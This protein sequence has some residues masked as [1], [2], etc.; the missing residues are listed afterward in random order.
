MSNTLQ[1]RA[2]IVAF[3]TVVLF[4]IHPCPSFVSRPLCRQTWDFIGVLYSRSVYSTA[5]KTKQ[6]TIVHVGTRVQPHTKRYGDIFGIE[7]MRCVSYL[8]RRP[9]TVATVRVMLFGRILEH[10]CDC[11]IMEQG[12]VAHGAGHYNSVHSHLHLRIHFSNRQA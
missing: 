2:V 10:C 1:V 11:D 8:P 7:A 12:K 3:S 4:E 6:H 5:D 9:R